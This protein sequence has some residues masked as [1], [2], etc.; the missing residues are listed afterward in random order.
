MHEHK[1][2]A[3]VNKMIRTD[4][5]KRKERR[6]EN[7]SKS[8]CYRDLPNPSASKLAFIEKTQPKFK[9][10]MHQEAFAVSLEE[11]LAMQ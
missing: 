8:K 7:A 6:I 4:F 2:D 10:Q 1:V 9:E 3:A 5:T 11:L